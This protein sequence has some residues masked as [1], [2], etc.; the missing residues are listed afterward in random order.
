MSGECRLYLVPV[1]IPSPVAVLKSEIGSIHAITGPRLE[2]NKPAALLATHL[3]YLLGARC[4]QVLAQPSVAGPDASQTLPYLF[5]TRN[6][7]IFQRSRQKAKGGQICVPTLHPQAV[8]LTSCACCHQQ[9]SAARPQ[10][11]STARTKY[12]AQKQSW[13]EHTNNGQ[14]DIC[15]ET[16]KRGC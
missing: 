4:M 11:R 8:A 1:S 5:R 16:F 3:T 7:S 6:L 2:P 13:S 15:D 14:P 9:R 10:A 12:H